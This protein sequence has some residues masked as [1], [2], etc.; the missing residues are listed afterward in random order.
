[1]KDAEDSLFSWGENIFNDA[2]VF[3]FK[4]NFVMIGRNFYGVLGAPFASRHL[5]LCRMD[6]E[7]IIKANSKQVLH[8]VH[9]AE[10]KGAK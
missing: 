6:V 10:E 2:N 3:I 9:R 5:S 8:S 1:M 4:F 7:G